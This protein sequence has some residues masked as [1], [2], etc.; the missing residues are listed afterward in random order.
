MLIGTKMNN[1]LTLVRGVS[2]S[3]KSTYAKSLGIPAHFE[4]DMYFYKDGEY[5]FNPRQLGDAHAWCR[6][7][8]E[9]HL[10]ANHD[11]V[12]SNTFIKKWEIQPY[13]D[14]ANELGIPYEVVELKTSYGNI[15]GVPEEKIKQMQ[16]NWEEL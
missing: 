5:R 11:V 1:K 2:G 12:V 6:A 14:L 8:T 13:I 10:R 16:E 15:H 9:Q 4:A 7:M 3:G